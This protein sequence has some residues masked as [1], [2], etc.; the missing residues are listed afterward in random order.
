MRA[1]YFTLA[2]DLF[3]N[4]KTIVD[5]DRVNEIETIYKT[6]KEFVQVLSSN[7]VIQERDNLVVAYIQDYNRSRNYTGLVASNLVN[8][9]GKPV[10]VLIKTS[11][12]LYEGSVRD[13]YGRN[14]LQIFK[15]VIEAHG[16]QPAFGVKI[17]KDKL[18]DS[19]YLLDSLLKT[20]DEKQTGVLLLDWSKY[21]SKDK[22][23]REDLQ[24]MSEYNEFSGNGLPVAYAKIQIR[25]NMRIQYSPKVTR[26]HWGDIELVLFGKYAST[27]D[28]VIVEPT[29]PG[30]LIVKN[31]QYNY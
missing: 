18:E 2:Y 19:I 14:L 30:K 27:G 23:L 25:N 5:T 28:V 24:L 8:K 29:H 17:H 7:A 1:E 10:M 4:I 3:Y 13:L 31:V 16:H 11:N 12:E 20:C 21:S 6:S 26:I 22:E 9:Y 15:T